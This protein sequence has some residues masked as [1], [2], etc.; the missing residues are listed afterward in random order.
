MLLDDLIGTGNQAI[1]LWRQIQDAFVLQHMPRIVYFALVGFRDAKE[2]VA[3]D[4]GMTVEERRVG[5]E[6]GVT[7]RQDSARQSTRKVSPSTMRSCA[8]LHLSQQ[9]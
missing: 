6:L 9:Q 3:E 7:T 2:T 8:N 4:T 1:T 5:L